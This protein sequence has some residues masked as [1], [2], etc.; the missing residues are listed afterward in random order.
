MQGDRMR[1]QLHRQVAL[2]RDSHSLMRQLEVVAL[3][4]AEIVIEGLWRRAVELDGEEEEIG[5]R[6][7]LDMSLGALCIK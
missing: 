3:E 5:L 2:V 4:E 6:E 7:R 1:R